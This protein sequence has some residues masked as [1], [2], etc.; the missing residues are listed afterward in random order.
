MSAIYV[1]VSALLLRILPLV[2]GIAVAR[3]LGAAE[4]ADFVLTLA[5]LSLI[6]SIF[7]LSV[8]PQ[9]IRSENSTSWG[10]FVSA[11]AFLSVMCFL[12]IACAIVAM[13][14]TLLAGVWLTTFSV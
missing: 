9:L 4:Y 7:Q 12:P 8:V 10:D 13:Q 5:L 2:F 1:V 3:T 14:G 11:S 6:A